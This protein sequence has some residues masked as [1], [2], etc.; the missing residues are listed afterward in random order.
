ME[1]ADSSVSSRLCKKKPLKKEKPLTELPNNSV[2]IWVVTGFSYNLPV[3]LCFLLKWF[4]HPHFLMSFREACFF[5][6]ILVSQINQVSFQWQENWDSQITFE[7]TSGFFFFA[8]F[9]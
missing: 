2:T 9:T 3:F 4:S 6:V 1:I 8:V 5:L 7:K